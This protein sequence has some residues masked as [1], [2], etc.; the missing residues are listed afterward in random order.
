[1]KAQAAAPDQAA[2]PWARRRQPR[3]RT[4]WTD[5]FSPISVGR[6]AYDVD[7]RPIAS[8]GNACQSW[9]GAARWFRCEQSHCRRRIPAP[10]LLDR[11]HEAYA[12]PDLPVP[13][14]SIADDLLG[15]FVEE[16]DEFDSSGVLLLAERRIVPRAREPDVRQ[17]FTLAHEIGRWVLPVPRPAHGPG[18]LPRRGYWSRSVCTG[19][20]AGGERVRCGAIDTRGESARGVAQGGLRSRAGGVVWGLVRSDGLASLQLRPRRGAAALMDVFGLRQRLVD[21]YADFTRSF[22]VIRDACS[23]S[24]MWRSPPH[25][26]HPPHGEASRHGMRG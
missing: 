2:P 26:P 19:G 16:S 11:F 4:K 7:G 14:E 13:V 12:A 21:D 3:L 8:A 1:M 10:R 9:P 15:L 5:S 6:M 22:V 23:P 24:S 18:L 20:R 25:P 17:R